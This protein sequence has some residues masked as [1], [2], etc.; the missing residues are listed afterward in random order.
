MDFLKCEK[1]SKTQQFLEKILELSLL[2]TISRPT[3]ITK[4]SATLIGNILA[5]QDLYF[6]TLGGI[7]IKDLSDHLP[8]V[9]VIKNIKTWKGETITIYKRD[10]SQTNIKLLKDS[11]NSNN[12]LTVLGTKP[13]SEQFKIFH[14]LLLEKL[15]K[16]CPKKEI[17]ISGKKIIREPWL[18][19]GLIKCLD[20]Q[21]HHYKEFLVHRI[22]NCENKYKVY[23][24]T[25]QQII[26][27]VKKTILYWPMY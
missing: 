21:K 26:R 8:C 25:L 27:N 4:N 5:G 6:K 10:T 12:W 7:V 15:D 22:T 13:T 17:K 14:S 3:R 23:R 9:C 18:T 20:K 24:N 11:M 1:Q 16:F 2:A 19:K